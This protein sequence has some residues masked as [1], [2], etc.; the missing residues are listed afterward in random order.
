MFFF[1]WLKTVEQENSCNRTV[2][3]IV[4]KMSYK[5]NNRNSMNIWFI[6][7]YY[8]LINIIDIFWTD[9]QVVFYIFSV[10][11]SVWA[12]IKRSESAQCP[13]VKGHRVSASLLQGSGRRSGCWEGRRRRREQEERERKRRSGGTWTSLCSENSTGAPE[14]HRRD[15]LRCFCSGQVSGTGTCSWLFTCRGIRLV[16]LRPFVRK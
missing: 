11:L 4:F 14:R 12:D 8:I 3:G 7:I 16:S 2:R 5:D 15:T 10:L 9:K 6:N 1:K 13:Q